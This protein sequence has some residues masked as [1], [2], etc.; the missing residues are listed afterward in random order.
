M[1]PTWDEIWID[2]AKVV[3]NRSNDPKFK[4][5][6][7]IVTRDNESVLSIGYNGDEKGGGN[8]RDSLDT[9]C[10]GFIHAEINAVTKMNY[11]DQRPRK[12]YL[13]HS[14]CLVC[15]RVLINA[16]ITEVIFEDEYE[17]DAKGLDILRKHAIVVRQR[18]R[19]KG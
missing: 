19:S 6:A 14:P 15:A 16:K 8:L 10:S 12:I 1:K 4:V 13:T 2:L 18:K 3:S 5:G 17:S 7:V 9:G 11:V